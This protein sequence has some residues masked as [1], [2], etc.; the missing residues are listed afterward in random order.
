MDTLIRTSAKILLKSGAYLSLE[1]AETIF[2]RMSVKDMRTLSNTLR[3]LADVVQKQNSSRSFISQKLYREKRN[4][5]IEK[6][7]HPYLEI[8]CKK[9]LKP[10]DYVKFEGNN[11]ES[12]RMVISVDTRSVFCRVCNLSRKGDVIMSE[13]S[14]QNGFTKLNSICIKE[15]NTSR[16]ITRKE[17]VQ[18]VKSQENA[19]V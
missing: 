15:G 19:N 7:I 11:A 9:Y 2:N 8:Y 18:F 1:S 3:E 17:I 13:Y 4:L 6:T 16:W 5:E 10:G 14:S 12:F